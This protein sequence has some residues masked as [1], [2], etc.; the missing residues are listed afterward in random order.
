MGK[1]HMTLFKETT[2]PRKNSEETEYPTAA[3]AMEDDAAREEREKRG[4]EVKQ[5][6]LA[7]VGAE[8]QTPKEL[9]PTTPN[10][11]RPGLP[12]VRSGGRLKAGDPN[13]PPTIEGN[14]ALLDAVQDPY[15]ERRPR[16][17][18]MVN[19]TDSYGN[20]VEIPV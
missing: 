20:V 5:E 2:M 11:L 12:P 16:P 3:E 18:S 15:N 8:P 14:Q 6:A 10:E 7:E 4:E 9:N 19:A 17:V 1:I 13:A